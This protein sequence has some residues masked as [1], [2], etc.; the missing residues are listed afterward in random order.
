MRGVQSDVRTIKGHGMGEGATDVTS[1]TRW[2]VLVE[3]CSVEDA[4]SVT[5]DALIC[6]E[7]KP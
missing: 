7:G 4:T 5:V 2:Y 6:P 3:P 1:L